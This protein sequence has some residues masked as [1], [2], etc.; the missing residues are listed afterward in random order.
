MS[1]PTSNVIEFQKKPLAD[2]S[3]AALL[4]AVLTDEAACV[5]M[6]GGCGIAVSQ[7]GEPFPNPY[8]AV[9][10]NPSASLWAPPGGKYAV[11]DHR[12]VGGECDSKC[13][14]LD[15][16]HR[17]QVVGLLD[18]LQDGGPGTR[19]RKLRKVGKAMW[20]IRLAADV[21]VIDL[22]TVDAQPLRTDAPEHVQKLWA[23]VLL[24]S[25]CRLRYDPS[26]VNFI[27]TKSFFND[28][29][30]MTSESDFVG[31]KMWLY[32]HGF[33]QVEIPGEW[34]GGGGG[35]ATVYRLGDADEVAKFDT[36]AHQKETAADD[37]NRREAA[38]R[39]EPSRP[40]LLDGAQRESYDKL[41]RER[42]GRA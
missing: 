22:P 24:L 8:L 39:R 17:D 15:Q 38:L 33:I 14:T 36:A 31:G 5:R 28:W 9:D 23:G 19:W 2:L 13:V 29:A 7:A 42:A 32:R 40:E 30:N 25:A 41:M 34:K 18:E 1:G 20:L 3:G 6:L 12:G 4:T 35:R 37:D 27:A 21:G 11:W 16:L 26:N 10:D